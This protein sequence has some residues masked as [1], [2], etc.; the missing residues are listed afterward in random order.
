MAW[1]VCN[2]R[3]LAT[4]EVADG[5]QQRAT[6]L[7]GC[8]EF[9]NAL[10]L[11]PAFWVHTIAMRFPIDVAYLDSNMV[12]LKTTTMAPHRIGLPVWKA[13][14]VLETEAGSLARWGIMPQDRLEI[15]QTAM[16]TQA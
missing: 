16:D 8:K 15:R 14:A 7:L 9:E 4:V 5:W 13:R 11:R 10:L 3:V 2:H 1:L 6:G 12:V